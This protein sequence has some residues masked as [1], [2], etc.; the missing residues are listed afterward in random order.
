MVLFTPKDIPGVWPMVRHYFLLGKKPPLTE[1][2]NPL[3]KLAYTS[4]ILL[5]IVS[6]VSGLVLYNPVQFS[7]IGWIVG[8]FHYARLV[9]FIAMWAFI[10][11]IVGHLLMVVLHGWSNFIAMLTGWKKDPE[12]LRSRGNQ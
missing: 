12:Y 7:W 2:Y 3:Q 1:E 10:A 4:A 11:F 6:V 5:G 8:G 9:H